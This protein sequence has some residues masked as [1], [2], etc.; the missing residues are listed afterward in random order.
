M[1]SKLERQIIANEVDYPRAT[2][3]TL[4]S[5]EQKIHEKEIFAKMY[6]RATGQ[7]QAT[8][9]CTASNSSNHKLD[10]KTQPIKLHNQKNY[11]R[12]N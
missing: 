8:G 6:N 9:S 7:T 1:P 2:K 3:Y 11:P 12:G 4:G 5:R 10:A